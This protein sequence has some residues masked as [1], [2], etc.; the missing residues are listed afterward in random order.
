MSLYFYSH[1]GRQFNGW[2]K[3]AKSTSECGQSFIVIVIDIGVCG[4]MCAKISILQV[5]KIYDE[6]DI[7]ALHWYTEVAK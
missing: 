6:I 1:R 2:F 5:N 3:V 7:Y 4:D